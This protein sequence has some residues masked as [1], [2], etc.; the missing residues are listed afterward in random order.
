M[1]EIFKGTKSKLAKSELILFDANFREWLS[2]NL[3]NG[4]LKINC[5]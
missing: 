3:S 4:K 5:E 1:S 2:N